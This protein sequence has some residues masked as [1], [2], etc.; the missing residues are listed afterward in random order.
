[1]PIRTARSLLRTT[2]RASSRSAGWNRE[3]PQVLCPGVNRQPRYFVDDSR[4]PDDTCRR[5][6]HCFC[7]VDDGSSVSAFQTYLDQYRSL[8]RSLRRRLTSCSSAAVAGLHA[9]RRLRPF[10]RE[11]PAV[12]RQ[13]R[14]GCP[15]AAVFQGRALYRPAS[16]TSSRRRM[17]S[18]VMGGTAFQDSV[19]AW[20]EQCA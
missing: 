19:R 17:D 4:W 10:P 12:N 6:P 11:T 13:R 16:S 7:Y 14:P 15:S 9:A 20:F 2:A 18:Y 3:S 1:L 8:L 5:P